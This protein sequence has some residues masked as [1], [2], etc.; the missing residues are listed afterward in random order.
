M[1]NSFFL[2]KRTFTGPCGVSTIHP[3]FDFLIDRQNILAHLGRFSGFE[4]NSYTLPGSQF[5]ATLSV[6]DFNNAAT[7]FILPSV[8]FRVTRKGVQKGV[9]SAL[10]SSL[11]VLPNPVKSPAHCA[12]LF[13][14]PLGPPDHT[15]DRGV[16]RN[17]EEPG[18]LPQFHPTE[19]AASIHGQG[20]HLVPLPPPAQE[21]SLAP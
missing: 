16:A 7:S 21:Q 3:P 10:D 17:L 19:A 9:K 5:M 14:L 6:L 4:T 11:E 15:A 8:Q 20:P 13:Q 18:D 2:V 12:S 1:P